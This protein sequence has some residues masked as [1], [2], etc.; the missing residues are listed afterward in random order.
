MKLQVALLASIVAK[1]SGEIPLAVQNCLNDP[2]CDKA[3]ICNLY[4]GIIC[5]H[6]ECIQLHSGPQWYVC[7]CTEEG[8]VEDLSLQYCLRLGEALEAP[9]TTGPVVEDPDPNTPSPVDT[10]SP[11]NTP[12]P[13]GTPSPVATSCDLSQC[14]DAAVACEIVNGTPKC[15]CPDGLY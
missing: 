6:G 12:S 4:V 9:P 1:A 13:V 14:D 7:E 10:P 11:I 15:L 3:D 5:E 2:E 8:F